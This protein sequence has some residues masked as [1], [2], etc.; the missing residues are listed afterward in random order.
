MRNVYSL[1]AAALIAPT[2]FVSSS[3]A[4]NARGDSVDLNTP[5]VLD[6]LQKDR[7]KHYEAVT[8]AM[9]VA[10]H[11]PCKK[12]ELEMLKARFDLSDIACTP[13][14][15]TS[16]PPKRQ[17]TLTLDGTV[18]HASVMVSDMKGEFRPLASPAP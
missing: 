8:E 15:K 13:I 3:L 12:R 7:P 4:A 14:L 5:G 18:Y 10:E 1:I 9:R 17:L 11:T 2:L 16:N 6:Q